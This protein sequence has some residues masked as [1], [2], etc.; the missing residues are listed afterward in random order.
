MSAYDGREA[1]A[2]PVM[3][4][5]YLL[6]SQVPNS[7]ILPLVYAASDKSPFFKEFIIRTA[8]IIHIQIPVDLLLILIYRLASRIREGETDA[9][10]VSEVRG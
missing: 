8:P 3:G 5:N 6:Y 10:Q 4:V 2:T 1:L 7:F 9:L